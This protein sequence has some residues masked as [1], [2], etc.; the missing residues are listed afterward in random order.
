MTTLF[1]VKSRFGLLKTHIA[2][3]VAEI[4]Q[5]PSRNRRLK[6]VGSVLL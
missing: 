4:N 2:T 6:S 1:L 3:K 5:N